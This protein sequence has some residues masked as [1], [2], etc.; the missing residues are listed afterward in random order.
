MYNK[1]SELVAA[2]VASFHHTPVGSEQTIPCPVC[3][4]Y[5]NFWGALTDT[6]MTLTEGHRVITGTL[7]AKKWN[8]L[9]YA[10]SIG[11]ANFRGSGYYSLSEFLSA[12]NLRPNIT[13]VNGQMAI[14]LVEQIVDDGKC[15]DCTCACYTTSESRI[16]QPV[17]Q[18]GDVQSCLEA[19]SLEEIAK[20]MNCSRRV[21][22]EHWHVFEGKIIGAALGTTVI[23]ETKFDEGIKVENDV[24]AKLLDGEGLGDLYFRKFARYFSLDSDDKKWQALLRRDKNN[25]V[26]A[27]NFDDLT[28]QEW[29]ENARSIIACYN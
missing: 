23:L 5:N 18:L 1:F 4:T 3:R 13:T 6:H 26:F 7:D 8:N 2:G 28:P 15:C 22:G 12:N 14:E 24:L 20:N 21:V 27:R 16:P 11:N 29:F 9:L 17:A 19:R 25:K 10:S